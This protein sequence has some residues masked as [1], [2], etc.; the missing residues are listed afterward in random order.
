MKALLE[1]N[2]WLWCTVSK[3]GNECWSGGV[4]EGGYMF[5]WGRG[6]KGSL[7]APLFLENS[8]SYLYPSSRRSGIGI[9]FFFPPIYPRHFKLLLLYCISVGL[10]VKL[11][12][13]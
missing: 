1:E 3:L 6:G 9:H 11:L 12:S 8:S 10:F 5:R 2:E 7:S 13:L 4:S